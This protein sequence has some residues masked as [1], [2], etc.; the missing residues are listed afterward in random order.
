MLKKII[1][2]GFQLRQMCLKC[3]LTGCYKYGVVTWRLPL[4]PWR[5]PLHDVCTTT[6]TIILFAEL[7][8]ITA[9]TIISA[10]DS[11]TPQKFDLSLF[12]GVTQRCTTCGLQWWNL[13]PSTFS[14]KY[15]SSWRI[16][17][18]KTCW[19]I[20]KK[21]PCWRIL[22]Q[23]KRKARK[24]VRNNLDSDLSFKKFGIMFDILLYF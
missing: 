1:T 6:T 19:C 21:Q 8:N 14:L 2:E 9:G 3:A 12:K 13:P 18:I 4:P 22:K 11:Q 15:K 23:N 5:L 20:L 17:Q 10:I 24:S 7:Y 16:F